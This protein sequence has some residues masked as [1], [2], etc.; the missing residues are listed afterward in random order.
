MNG[1]PFGHTAR[2]KISKWHFSP[3][4]RTRLVFA[5]LLVTLTVSLIGL[6]MNAQR[7]IT[8]MRQATVAALLMRLAAMRV[9]FVKVITDDSPEAQAELVDELNIYEDIHHIYCAITMAG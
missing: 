5:I 9:D 4:I 3:G 6:S 1:A 8:R 2:L 7:D